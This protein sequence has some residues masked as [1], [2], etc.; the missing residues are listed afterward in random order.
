VVDEAVH[1]F[2]AV[3]VG[4]FGDQ[5]LELVGAGEDVLDALDFVEGFGELLFWSS[6]NQSVYCFSL[7]RR[8]V[9]G[10]QSHVRD[11]TSLPSKKS[12]ATSRV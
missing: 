11:F 5:G 4:L 10:N 9:R 12:V 6:E 3:V 1:D 7:W 2:E 8:D